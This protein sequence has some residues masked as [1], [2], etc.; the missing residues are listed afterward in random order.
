MSL[1]SEQIPNDNEQH[2]EPQET[3]TRVSGMFKD[4]FLD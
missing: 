1:D 4:W 2:Q 3:I